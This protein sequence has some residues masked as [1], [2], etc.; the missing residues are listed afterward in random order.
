MWHN[1]RETN[2]TIWLALNFLFPKSVKHHT[3]KA[4]IHWRSL[5]WSGTVFRI[6]HRPGSHVGTRSSSTDWVVWVIATPVSP[7][8]RALLHMDHQP[9]GKHTLKG[10]GA[11]PSE[12][13]T[14]RLCSGRKLRLQNHTSQMGS[15]PWGNQGLL[16]DFH[17][18]QRHQRGTLTIWAKSAPKPH[19]SR[20]TSGPTRC[21][22]LGLQGLGWHHRLWVGPSKAPERPSQQKQAKEMASQLSELGSEI[23]CI[24]N[25]SLSMLKYKHFWEAYKWMPTASR[26][27]FQEFSCRRWL[28]KGKGYQRLGK[29]WEDSGRELKLPARDTGALGT[30]LWAWLPWLTFLWVAKRVDLKQ[31]HHKNMSLWDAGYVNRPYCYTHF[32]IKVSYHHVTYPE[33]AQC[34]IS[35]IYKP[36]WKNLRIY[37][38]Y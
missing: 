31:S 5:G 36:S 10:W 3:L 6:W 17:S 34:F 13:H 33:L 8:P 26:G 16:E 28:I 35:I 21:S 1:L 18:V 27:M 24:E 30:W 11:G 29:G 23:P 19:V 2:H 15:H 12:I 32:A 37:F 22:E 9:G 20:E 25:C 4:R 38:T 7:A 14:C